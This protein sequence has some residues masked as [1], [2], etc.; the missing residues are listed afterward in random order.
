MCS[1][2]AKF[3]I[4]G[5]PFRRENISMKQVLLTALIFGWCAAHAVHAENWPG[6]R[7]PRG[8]GSSAEVDVPVQWNAATGEN[9]RWKTPVSY[10]GHSSPIVWGDRVFVTGANETTAQRM[11]LC[12]DRADG[13]VLWE[14]AVDE[15]PLEKKHKLNSWASGTPAAD[16]AHIF[17]TFLDEADMLVAAFDFAGRE[18]W[19][20]RPGVFS[21]VHGYC[22][23]PVLFEQLVIVNGDHDGEAYLVALNRSTG[24][25]VWKTPRENKTRSYCTPIIRDIDGRTQMI[26]SGSKCVASYDPRTGKRWWLLDGPTEQFVASPV[27]NGGLVF[28]TGGFPD[29]HILAIDPRGAGKITDETHVKWRH[30]NRGVSYV[31]SPVAAG[32]FFFCVSDAG[33]GSC[34]D[35][36]TGD[37]NWQERLGPHHSGSLVSAAGKVYFLDDDG[38]THVVAAEKAF[39]VLAKNS[40]GEAAYSSPAI[41]AGQVFIRGEQHLF[42]LEQTVARNGQTGAACP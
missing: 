17:V 26:L 20:V 35:A 10:S 32:P 28:I 37:V 42:C 30:L 36:A 21:S 33:I 34:Y 1:P 4:R 8:D 31:P 5:C 7:G 29:K 24:Q 22:S 18:V 2:E 12:L 16:G 3:M 13:H 11:L 41:S 40:L 23:C 14:R 19:K 38:V 15:A 39:R 6:W 27:M 25:T 9:L